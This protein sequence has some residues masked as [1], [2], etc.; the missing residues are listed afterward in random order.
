MNLNLNIFC[1]LRIF[2][3]SRLKIIHWCIEIIRINII[4]QTQRSS[5]PIFRT[6]RLLVQHSFLYNFCVLSLFNTN[7]IQY[8][9][10]PYCGLRIFSFISKGRQN[11]AV[12]II[13]IVSYL[14]GERIIGL[15]RAQLSSVI[16]GNR[17]RQNRNCW[18][19][20]KSRERRQEVQEDV[21]RQTN[22]K[23]TA[24]EF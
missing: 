14:D 4:L 19:T 12:Q 24:L 5:G 13:I 3:I 1:F 21:E 18:W 9:L 11:N 2:N 17:T 16:I 23:L 8:S 20:W 7:T 22:V 6:S 10:H 15:K